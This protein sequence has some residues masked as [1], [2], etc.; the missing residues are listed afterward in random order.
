[1]EAMQMNRRRTFLMMFILLASGC[2]PQVELAPT[3][4]SP[5]ELPEGTQAL[6]PAFTPT[7]SPA[8]TL[9]PAPTPD[10]PSLDQRLG[11]LP[12]YVGDVGALRD[13]TQY[14]IEID[15]SF[16][17]RTQEASIDGHA[18]ILF[19]NPLDDRLDDI[20]LMLWP[21][22]DQYAA[23][24][25]AG[26]AVIQDEIV[27]GVSID[28]SPGLYFG[29]PRSIGPGESVDLSLP[30]RLEIGMMSALSPKRMG[31][32]ENIVLAPT[33]YPLVPRFVN[34]EWQ[35]ADAPPGGDTTNSD[36]AFYQLDVTW[37]AT[38]ELVA[39]GVELNKRVSTE[40]K[41][42]TFISGPM[43]DVA[44]ALGPFVMEVIEVGEVALQAW[45]LPEHRDDI[46]IVLEAAAG[47][48]T[49]LEELL[50]PYPYPE[51]DL[52]DAPGA[53][54]GIEY[55]GLVYLGTLGSNWV[56]EPTV[57]E[58]A[59]QWFYGLIGDDQIQ[60]PWLDEAAATYAEA[61]YYE[62][63][64]GTGRGTSFLSDL[65]AIIRRH[66]DPELPIGLAVGEYQNEFEYAAFVYLKG[67]LFFDALRNELDE[68]GFSSFLQ[69]YFE[70][71]RYRF[72]NGE[73]FQKIAESTCSC[74]LDPLFDLWVYDGG[75]IPELE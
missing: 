18:R 46:E 34:S 33:F 51:L 39:S 3:R 26:P 10:I 32:T 71:Y 64:H 68:S 75:R 12:A 70:T 37:P 14:W 9:T 29:L 66:P 43:R 5:G 28:G 52:V 65:R 30:F 25:V 15:L 49:V 35:T 73:G 53:F 1:M 47:Q 11:L 63:T 62:A 20:V 22:N 58:V 6:P 7:P 67:A 4:T 56:I 36:I 24:M 60:E 72:A 41:H 50:G 27:E 45:V 17:E 59:H 16:D 8:P 42:A 40:T 74:E 2:L 38:Y 54:G 13:A 48:M 61:L 44:I 23:S 31:I 69:E 55:P 21:N 19:T 57:H